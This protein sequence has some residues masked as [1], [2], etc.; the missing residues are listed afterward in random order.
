ML[1]L[2]SLLSLSLPP[3]EVIKVNMWRMLLCEATAAIMAKGFEIL[4]INPVQRM[5]CHVTAVP[6]ASER[7]LAIS[8]LTRI[9]DQYQDQ[10][11]K[12]EEEEDEKI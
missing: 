9:Q 11:Q 3:G 6:P 12:E 1:I 8:E 5:W 10:D 2:E 4:G 7:V